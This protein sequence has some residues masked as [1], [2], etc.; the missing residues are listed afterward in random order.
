MH[1]S[2]VPIRFELPST[3]WR[4]LDP[5]EV[6]VTNVLFMAARAGVEGDFTPTI[7][8]SG[9]WRPSTDS[10]TRIGEESVAK[11]RAEGAEEVEVV[12]RKLIESTTAPALT[13]TLGAIAT[14]KAKRFDLRQSQVITGYVDLESPERTAVFIHTLTCTFKQAPDMVDE[15][16]SF[17]DSVAPAETPRPPAD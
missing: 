16:K 15:F 5:A 8:I 11:L 6:G 13:Q 14:I 4:P 3:A 12:D 10:L 9:G 2:P 1:Q 7:S 17:I